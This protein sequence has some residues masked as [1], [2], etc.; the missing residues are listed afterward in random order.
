MSR[1]GVGP[2]GPSKSGRRSSSGHRRLAL[3]D[4]R[5]INEAL[6]KMLCHNICVLVRAMHE[7]ERDSPFS[8]K[9]KK[10]NRKVFYRP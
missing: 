10:L 2:S 8:I 6:C 4:T 5:Q 3:G 1:L 9:H 7:L